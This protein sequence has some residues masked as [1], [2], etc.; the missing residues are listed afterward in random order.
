[1]QQG[2]WELLR[3]GGFTLGLLLLGSVVSW[4]VI[5]E[6]F[7]VY[8]K[9][10]RGLHSFH[11]KLMNALIKGDSDAV[12]RLCAQSSWIPSAPVLERAL[13]RKTRWREALER[14]RLRIGQDLKRRLWILGTF[15]AAAPF[16][17]LFG[18]VVG[19]LQAFREM[20]KSGTGGFTV[21]AAGISEAL[22]A[23]AAGILVAVVALL[24]FNAFQVKLSRL[25]FE[26]RLQLEEVAEHLE[27]DAGQKNARS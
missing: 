3:Q 24:A 7:W 4:M 17:G 8:R 12:R 9:L 16:V 21:V 22:V 6:R 5:F 11:L 20:A 10:E 13:E 19:I 25:L 2:T 23:T 1:M 26:I 27:D 18:T 15:A 14:D